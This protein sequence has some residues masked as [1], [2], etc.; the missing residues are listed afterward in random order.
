MRRI[1]PYAPYAGYLPRAIDRCLVPEEHPAAADGGRVPE[2]EAVR[3]EELLTLCDEAVARDGPGARLRLLIPGR[4]GSRTHARLF[5][6]RGGPRGRIVSDAV[7]DGYL[8]V[9]FEAGV[10]AADLRRRLAGADRRRARPR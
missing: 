1:R 8:L 9:E 10:V 7:R 5:G 4:W 3:P 6:R 2:E